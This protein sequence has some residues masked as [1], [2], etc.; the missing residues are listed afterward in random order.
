MSK[1]YNIR[2]REDDQDALRKAVK[3]FNAKL[4]RLEQKDPTQKNALPDRITVKQMKELITTRQDLQRELN[5]LRRFTRPGAEQLIEIPEHEYNMKITKWQKEEMTRRVAIINRKRK[6]RY[7]AIR[8]LEMQ[9]RGEGLG[10]TVEEADKGIGMKSVDQNAAAP[11]NAFS[12][13]MTRPDL[14]AK[15][16]NIMKESQSAYWNRREEIMKQTYK[17]TLLENFSEKDIS[18]VISAID[19]MSFKDFYSKFKSDS[20]KFESLYPGDQT[21]YQSYV[22]GLKST[23][24][25]SAAS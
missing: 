21:Q 11:M 3:N 15:F 7:D 5:A 14:R 18:D 13:K 20:G 6:D 25:P 10:Y 1:Q 4:T 17:K 2:W 22:E 24:I 8:E 9:D 19:E 16:R 23:W 12:G